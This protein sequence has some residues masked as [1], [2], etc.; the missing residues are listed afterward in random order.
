MVLAMTKL[1][2]VQEAILQLDREEQARLW[3]W[4]DEKALDPRQDGPEL[5]AELLHAVQGPHTPLIKA[6]LEAVAAR[7]SRLVRSQDS[8]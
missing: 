2:A 5:E 3:I 4:L 7:A 8:A 6:D 1:A